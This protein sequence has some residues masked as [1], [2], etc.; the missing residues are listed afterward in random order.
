MHDHS[1]SQIAASNRR[2][3]KSASKWEAV[4]SD[5]VRLSERFKSVQRTIYSMGFTCVVVMGEDKLS[6]EHV[7][8]K[9]IL[10]EKLHNLADLLRARYELS[11]HSSLSHP[12]IVPVLAGEETDSSIVIVTPLAKSDLHSLALHKVFSESNCRRLARQLLASLDYLHNTIK[13]VHGDIKPHNILIFPSEDD[14]HCLTARL[15]DFGFTEPVLPGEVLR[16]RGMKGSLGYFSPE[17]LRRDFFGQPVDIFALGI[18]LYH[19]LCGYEPFYPSNKA[20]QLTGK[21]DSKILH[22]DSPEWSEIS[23]ECIEFLRGLLCGDPAIRWTAQRA[24]GSQWINMSDDMT[25]EKK[26]EDADI[27]FA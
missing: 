8:I 18:I 4:L 19:M 3:F 24:I 20:G 2:M 7:A 17:Q 13:V 6:H 15:C 16:D 25:D 23:S 5:D 12:N 14:P 21:D 22:F 11:L 10:K 27:Q 26:G 9:V 1:S